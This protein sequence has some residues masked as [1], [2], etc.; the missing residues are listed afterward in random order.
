[1]VNYFDTN[2]RIVVQTIVKRGC[3]FCFWLVNN[4]PDQILMPTVTIFAIARKAIIE[5]E[6]S[7][8][9]VPQAC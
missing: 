7:I 1:M 9:S 2:I 5:L 3:D 6:I 4:T 8:I